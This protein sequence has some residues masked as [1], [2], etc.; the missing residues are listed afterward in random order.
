[1]LRVR[2]LLWR[3]RRV[4]QWRLFVKVGTCEA[5]KQAADSKKRGVF[6]PDEVV[7]NNRDDLAD[8]ADDGEVRGGHKL[9]RE[10]G[11]VRHGEAQHAGERQRRDGLEAPDDVLVLRSAQ[12]GDDQGHGGE[13]VA[14]VHAPPVRIHLDGVDDVLD[15]DLVDEEGDVPDGEPRV[16][17]DLEARV[18]LH[19]EVRADRE[20]HKRG[21]TLLVGK[22]ASQ[23]QVV[24]DG[25]RAGRGGAEDDE[26]LDVRVLQRLHV[27]EERAHE[28]EGYGPKAHHLFHD[29]RIHLDQAAQAEHEDGQRGDGQLA[30][31]HERGRGHVVH[32]ELVPDQHH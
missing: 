25:D 16:G 9:A 19:V 6:V 30:P 22:L 1:M 8:V 31:Q 14:V 18:R 24:A 29:Q 4:S 27:A 11:E 21:G 26:R 17:D 32:S 20:A 23:E 15:V 5:A 28:N 7:D 12:P 10:E 3:R 2:C 13:Q